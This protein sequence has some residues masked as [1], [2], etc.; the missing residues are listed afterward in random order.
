MEKEIRPKTNVEKVT[1]FM[2]FGNP[3]KQVFVLEALRHYTK[4]VKENEAELKAQTNSF[5]NGTAWVGCAYDWDL[6]QNKT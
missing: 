3:L 5:V 1:E 4:H 2:E 6:V